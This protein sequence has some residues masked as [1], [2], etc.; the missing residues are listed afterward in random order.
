MTQRIKNFSWLIALILVT[1]IGDRTLGF[2]LKKRA[3]K[4]PF[5][6]SKLYYSDSLDYKIVIVG[7]SRGNTF[8]APELAQL[9]HKKTLNLSMDALPTDLICCLAMDY[10]DRHQPPEVLIVEISSSAFQSATLKTDF[11]AFYSLSERLDSLIKATVLPEDESAGIKMAVGSQ[12]S[13][14][15]RYNNSHFLARFLT[16]SPDPNDIEWADKTSMDSSMIAHIKYG[17]WDTPPMEAQIEAIIKLVNYAQA[18]Q[19]KIKLLIAP[20][21]PALANEIRQPVLI[22]LTRRIESSVNIKVSDYSTLIG[23]MNLFANPSHL[24]RMGS[25]KMMDT[26]NKIHFFE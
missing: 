18:K 19:V 22:P 5:R 7:S 17:Y 24:N 14:L 1:F 9:T 16:Y 3:E 21:L 15:F 10:L 13:W 6:Y 26:L 11:K 4:A 25:L 2:A 23:N 20:F 12:L 8:H